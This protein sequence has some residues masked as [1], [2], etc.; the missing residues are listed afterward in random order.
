[1]KKE[2]NYLAVFVFATLIWTWIAGFMPI[3][4]GIKDESV[5]DVL[6]KAF[7]GPVPS[8]MGVILVFA[9]YSKEKRRD[10]FKRCFSIKQMG[11]IVPLAVMMLYAVA[12]G[13]SVLISTQFF[14]GTVP[15]FEGIRTIIAKP[16]MIFLYLFF[17][18]IS[19]PLNEEFGWRG[20]ALEPL[21][22]KYGFWLGSAILGFIW[23]IWHLP[24]YFY[25]GN[26]QYIAWNVSWVAGIWMI[27]HS[28]T[29]SCVVSI[30]YVKRN[31]SI[32]MGAF[33]HMI[34]NFFVG[35][36]LIYPFDNT[37]IVTSIFVV[38]VLELLVC[39]CFAFN[40]SFKNEAAERI[41]KME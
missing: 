23:G 24:W 27:V 39:V 26:G 18:L 10:Y 17:A 8:I 12:C 25:P 6:F 5:Q 37:Y 9:T 11:I 38:S 41:Q 16:Y 32:M 2:K 22:K 14:G 15:E 3:I 31:R 35:G 30:A 19:G 36:T 33:V 4:F 34:S 29:C 20:F 1:M 21:M 40:K 7:A 28:I 13:L